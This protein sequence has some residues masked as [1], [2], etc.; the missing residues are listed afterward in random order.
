MA[1]IKMN[2]LFFLDWE[3]WIVIFILLFGEKLMKTR[4]I[5][6]AKTKTMVK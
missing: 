1:M 2:R 4:I 5:A 3:I 6:K